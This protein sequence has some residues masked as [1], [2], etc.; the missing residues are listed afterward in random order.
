MTIEF[1]PLWCNRNCCLFGVTAIVVLFNDQGM[2]NTIIFFETAVNGVTVRFRFKVQIWLL[3]SKGQ[4]TVPPRHLFQL[5]LM[6]KGSH[7]EH[8]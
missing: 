3:N 1:L 7:E 6:C 5:F 4:R 8:G 2:F